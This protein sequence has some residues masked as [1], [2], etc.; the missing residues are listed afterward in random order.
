MV[1]G[2]AP[3]VGIPMAL[4]SYGGSV[5]LTVMAGFGLIL[6]VRVHRYQELPR[7]QSIF[8]RFE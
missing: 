8:A 2:L 3:V 1:M 5:M 6:G 4:V 7:Q